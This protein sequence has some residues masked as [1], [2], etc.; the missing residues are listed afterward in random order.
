MFIAVEITYKDE[1]LVMF[2]SKEE[3][4]AWVAEFPYF[5]EALD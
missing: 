1:Q 4:D 2:D 3:R 5:R